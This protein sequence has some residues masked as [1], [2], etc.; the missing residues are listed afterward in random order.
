M[1]GLTLY[2]VTETRLLPRILKQGL[3][4]LQ[5][6]NWVDGNG[7]RLGGG[8]VHAFE[9]LSDALRWAARMDWELHQETGSGKIVVLTLESEQTWDTDFNDTLTQALYEG[10]WLK[11]YAPVPAHAIKHTRVLLPEDVRELVQETLS[12]GSVVFNVNL[13]SEGD[14]NS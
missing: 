12:D 6:S 11:L 3:R 8:A 13:S 10:R 9:S 4:C 5:P 7:K 14:P 2:H 1:A